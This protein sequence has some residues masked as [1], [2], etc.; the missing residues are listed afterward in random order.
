MSKKQWG[1]LLSCG[2]IIALISG[3][4]TIYFQTKQEQEFT[5]DPQVKLK[6]KQKYKIT[7]WDYQLYIGQKGDYEE[8]LQQAIKEFNQRYPQV[9][10][11][12]KLLSFVN[13]RKKLLS[14]LEQ[15]TPPDVYHA[16]WGS[17]L[18]D[19]QLQV[20]VSIFW[21]SGERGELQARNKYQQQSISTFSYQEEVWGLPQWVWPQVWIGNK[22]IFKKINFNVEKVSTEGWTKKEFYQ[23]SRQL[24]NLKAKGGIVLNPYNGQLMNQLLTVTVGNFNLVS[25]SSKLLVTA[26]EL[27]TGFKFLEQL[28]Q[29]EVFPV[30]SEQRAK[31]ML[32]YFWANQAGIIAPVNCWLA[33]RLYQEEKNEAAKIVL[34]PPPGLKENNKRP[35]VSVTGLLLFRQKE[36]QGDAHTKAAYKWAKF[37]NRKKSQ[38]ITQKL[39]VIPAVDSVRERWKQK[40]QLRPQLKKQLLSYSQHGYYKELTGFENQQLTKKIRNLIADNYTRYWLEDL[41]VYKAT[42][43]IIIKGESVT[44]SKN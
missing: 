37:I 6:S 4:L 20:P 23:A 9:K 17:K 26:E 12:Y 16:V 33:K 18:L 14:S 5:I 24:A 21:D 13:G 11:N 22:R 1:F 34:L 27:K 28:Q 35:P 41:S 2:L 10:V 29:L 39:K 8:F 32:P 42:K 3:G 44:S 7:Y 38:L 15:G 19:E 43:N 30:V 36:Y 40:V 25:N 31:K